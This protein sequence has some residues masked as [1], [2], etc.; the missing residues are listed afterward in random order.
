MITLLNTHNKLDNAHITHTGVGAKLHGPIKG[1]GM[2]PRVE[3]SLGGVVH[4][5]LYRKNP[6]L[7]IT[8]Y[9]RLASG[10]CGVL[11]VFDRLLPVFFSRLCEGVEEY[12]QQE[13]GVIFEGEGTHAGL[14][15]SQPHFPLSFTLTSTHIHFISHPFSPKVMATNRDLYT[16]SA[17]HVCVHPPPRRTKHGSE[18][19]GVSGE[20]ND[21]DNR[22]EGSGGALDD[23]G[24]TGDFFAWVVSYVFSPDSPLSHPLSLSLVLASFA[25]ALRR[26][27]YGS[28]DE[29]RACK[30]DGGSNEM[31]PNKKK[32]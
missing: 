5:K 23:V 6:R 32:D 30:D 22:G 8:A 13:A 15:V 31:M 17:A 21:E 16:H 28:C 1:E 10:V 27:V 29:S 12:Q 9:E 18:D 7:F 4:T 26:V 2:V 3:E 14:E 25:V 24:G 20:A 19:G 11:G